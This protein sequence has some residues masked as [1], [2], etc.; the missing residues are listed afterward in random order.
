MNAA[1]QIPIEQDTGEKIRDIG[2]LWR[3]RLTTGRN[4]RRRSR[5][6]SPIRTTLA[7]AVTWLFVFAVLGAAT[8]IAGIVILAGVGWGVVSAGLALLLAAVMLQVGIARG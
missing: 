7:S 6:T 3:R 1:P 4:K 8:T 2:P 5:K